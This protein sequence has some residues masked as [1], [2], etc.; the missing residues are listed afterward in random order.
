[1]IQKTCTAKVSDILGNP[2]V[3][4]KVGFSKKVICVGGNGKLLISQ[5]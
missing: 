3:L 2:R 5:L 4:C 1:M